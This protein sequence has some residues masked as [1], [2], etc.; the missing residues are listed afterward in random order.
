MQA[1]DYTCGPTSLLA[2]LSYYQVAEDFR[3]SDLA[4]LA[5]TT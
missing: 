2:V 1:T 5:K 3:E 4:K